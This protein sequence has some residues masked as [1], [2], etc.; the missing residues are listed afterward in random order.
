MQ[1]SRESKAEWKKKRRM[2]RWKQRR[3]KTKNEKIYIYG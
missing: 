3:V 2:D 1:K